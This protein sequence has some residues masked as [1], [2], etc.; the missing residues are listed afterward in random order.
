MSMARI[1]NCSTLFSPACGQND[2]LERHICI[3]VDVPFKIKKLRRMKAFI[4]LSFS[5]ICTTKSKQNRW[6]IYPD[7][8][9]FS[10]QK[11]K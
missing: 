11:R 3:R 5:P 6:V 4:R 2:Q 8:V 9:V 1:T 7:I 10:F